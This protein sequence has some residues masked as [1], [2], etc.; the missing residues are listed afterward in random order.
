M[1]MEPAVVEIASRHARRDANQSFGLRGRG[2]QLGHTLV[3][4]SVHAEAAISFGARAQPG[5][6]LGAITPLVPEGIEFAA[7]V[8]ASA[9][10]LDHYVVPMSREPDGMSKD[11]GGRNVA[12]VGL[13]HKQARVAARTGSI[14]MIGNQFHSV[15]HA[16][17]DPAFEAHAIAAI[18]PRG[19]TGAHGLSGFW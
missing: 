8:A 1:V 19:F 18:D 16:T 5:D 6:G 7:G 14:V 15:G 12:S 10:I 13:A 9:H 17:A 11:H 2:Q 4:K 3:G